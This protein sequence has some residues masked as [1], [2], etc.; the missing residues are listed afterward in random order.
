MLQLVVFLG[1]PGR[2][3]RYNRHNAAW[4]LAEMLSFSTALDWQKKFK[5][6]YAAATIG[7][8]NFHFIKPQTFM[9]LC[10]ESVFA[11]ASFYKIQLENIMVVHDEIELSP[12][13]LS[14]KFSGGLGGHNGL[15]SMKACFGSADFWRLRL[16]IGRPDGR[17]PGRGGD[18]QSSREAGIAAW[19]L[20]DFTADEANMLEPVFQT[21]AQLLEQALIAGPQSLLPEWAKKNCI[22]ANEPSE[23]V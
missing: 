10:G 2:K 19:V 18:I 3:Y 13:T 9:N 16:G 4:I 7:E 12:G 8:N 22:P 14:L 17:I 1:N 5:G 11:A 20:S 21:G 23:E 6:L 15:R